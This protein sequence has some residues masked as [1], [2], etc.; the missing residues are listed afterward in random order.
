ME[1]RINAE[2]P[3]Q[4]FMPSPGEITSLEVPGG[5][6]V[7]VDSAIYQGYT[8]PPFYDSLVGKLV[9]WGLNREEAIKRSGRALG[10]Y[11]LE[12][13]KTTIPLHLRL[14]EDAAFRSG[15]YNTGYLEGLLGEK[16]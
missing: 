14:L 6:G 5:P 3:D 7:R 10:E 12:G 8:I 4:D 16:G 15:E 1:F 2:D 9:V 11:R 13:I